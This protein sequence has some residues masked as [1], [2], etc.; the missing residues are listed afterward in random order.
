MSTF[1]DVGDVIDA[2]VSRLPAVLPEVSVTDGPSAVSSGLVLEVGVQNPTDQ[3]GREQA[4]SGSVEWATMGP[5]R[6]EDRGEVWL[7]AWSWTGDATPQ[8]ARQAA[9]GVRRSVVEWIRSL[10]APILDLAGLYEL[11]PGTSYTFDQA[12]T[13]DAWVAVLAFSLTYSA[14]I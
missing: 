8:Q 7:A 14:R 3:A 10:D 12:A 1:R 4:A 2:L 13:P 6:L 9:F 5:R 11:R